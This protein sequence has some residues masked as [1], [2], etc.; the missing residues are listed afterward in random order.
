MT[1]TKNTKDTGYVYEEESES[2]DEEESEHCCYGCEFEGLE[3]CFMIDEC[4]YMYCYSCVHYANG[5]FS[6]ENREK[7]SKHYVKVWCIQSEEEEEENKEQR[8]KKHDLFM[9]EDNKTKC[10]KC[11]EELGEEYAGKYAGDIYGCGYTGL[12]EQCNLCV[13]CNP[14]LWWLERRPTKLPRMVK[15]FEV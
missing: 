11:C 2:E 12:S 6:N 5:K 8:C 1:S 9:Y 15:E 13:K 10:S 3:S 4:G 7:G 14:K